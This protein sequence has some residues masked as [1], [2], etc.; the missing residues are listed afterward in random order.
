MSAMAANNVGRTLRAFGKKSKKWSGEVVFQDF[1]LTGTSCSVRVWNQFQSSGA[2]SKR[3]G[4][5][6]KRL[7][8]SFFPWMTS[9][10]KSDAINSQEFAA[11]PAK[12]GMVK[13]WHLSTVILLG[14]ILLGVSTSVAGQEIGRAHV[15][16]PVTRSSRMP[17]S[18]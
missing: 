6:M 18:P 10:N 4:C 17:S 3:V 2:F 9:W 15:S 11:L 13:R 12:A 5:V 1:D 8:G 14:A 16:T 7:V